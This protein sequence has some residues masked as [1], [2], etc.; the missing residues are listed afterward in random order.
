ME[1]V[2][3]GIIS[4]ASAL[5]A[6]ITMFVINMQ[7]KNEL[8]IHLNNLRSEWAELRDDWAYC[9][10]L[11]G[12]DY[13]SDPNSKTR[14]RY[15]EFLHDL[16]LSTSTED[17]EKEVELLRE[18]ASPMRRI[19]NYLS[20]VADSLLDGGISA[21]ETYI[22]LGPDVARHGAA[23]RIMT[24]SKTN[25]QDDASSDWRDDDPSYLSLSQLQ[26]IAESYEGE[27]ERIHILMDIL[28]SEM[29][30]RRDND[31]CS[32][33]SCALH[34]YTNE[35]GKVCRV[36]LR[37]H[38]RW[39]YINKQY[40]SLRRQLLEAELLQ[41]G[42]YQTGEIKFLPDF[43]PRIFRYGRIPFFSKQIG[44]IVAKQ[45]LEKSLEQ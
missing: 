21:K 3:L 43:E 25:F 30:R 1:S 14:T 27:Q 13:Y 17:I 40:Y 16:S 44:R 23:V 32:V 28:W 37:K 22:I 41:V 42:S 4:S 29:S 34:K 33:Y 9:L 38:C 35:T 11:C 18:Q 36:R 5:A 7:R 15:K 31:S 39:S 2:V 26:Q 19:C 45:N 20:Y 24:G 12:V 10:L 8:N 6:I